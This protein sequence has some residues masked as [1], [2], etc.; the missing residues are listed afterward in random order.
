MISLRTLAWPRCDLDG[1]FFL[2]MDEGQC[3]ILVLLDILVSLIVLIEEFLNTIKDPARKGGSSHVCWTESRVSIVPS[4]LHLSVH[5]QAQST[6][7]CETQHA[8]LPITLTW[9]SSAWPSPLRQSLA[10]S[11][12]CLPAWRKEGDWKS[13]SA[14]NQAQR[15][16]SVCDRRGIPTVQHISPSVWGLW[17]WALKADTLLLVMLNCWLLLSTQNTKALRKYAAMIVELAIHSFLPWTTYVESEIFT[18]KHRRYFISW[19]TNNLWGFSGFL[20]QYIFSTKRV[21]ATCWS[22]FNL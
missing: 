8:A 11:P 12:W 10:A 4:L 5:R 17:L 9:F 19:L 18:S 20:K 6:E 21:S 7:G 14:S 16:W 13:T 15:W 22:I 1:N 3:S 2:G